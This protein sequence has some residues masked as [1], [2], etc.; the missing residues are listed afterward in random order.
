MEE[1]LLGFVLL[2]GMGWLATSVYLVRKCRALTEERDTLALALRQ[3][4]EVPDVTASHDSKPVPGKSDKQLLWERDSSVYNCCIYIVPE[5]VG[6]FSV[7]MPRLPGVASQGDT[8]AE[9][10]ANCSEAFQGA[11]ET[12]REHCDQIPWRDEKD[13]ESCPAA[14]KKKHVLVKV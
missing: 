14:A 8:E 12:Y 9:A 10:I 4:R 1:V 11:I 7:W 2:G 6:G 5:E 3:R 13:V